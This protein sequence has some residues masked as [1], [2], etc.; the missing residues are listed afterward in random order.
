MYRNGFSRETG[1]W[2]T[3]VY[4]GQGKL[5][6]G[7][8]W[9]PTNTMFQLEPLQLPHSELRDIHCCCEPDLTCP[10]TLVSAS[11][12]PLDQPPSSSCRSPF[13][14]M[15]RYGAACETAQRSAPPVG[16][17]ARFSAS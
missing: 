15:R 11:R 14:C 3:V 1:V 8:F 13:R 16:L 6:A 2:S 9:S 5:P 4:G 12:P 7:A 17:T 10:S